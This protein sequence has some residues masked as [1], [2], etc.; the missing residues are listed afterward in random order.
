MDSVGG[1]RGLGKTRR[2]CSLGEPRHRRRG[3]RKIDRGGRLRSCSFLLFVGGGGCRTNHLVLFVSVVFDSCQE[4]EGLVGFI[5]I[6]ESRIEYRYRGSV[7]FREC[8]ARVKCFTLP[9]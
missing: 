7:T 9:L 8:S 6:S 4:R 1:R 3:L 2:S 5:S